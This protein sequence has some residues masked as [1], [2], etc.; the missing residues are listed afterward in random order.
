MKYEREK[1][2]WVRAG[3]VTGEAAG[4]P[5][6]GEKKKTVRKGK[7]EATI[8]ARALALEVT[9][10]AF[11][12]EVWFAATTEGLLASRDKGA[13]WQLFKFAP[14]NLPVA[15][16][17]ASLDGSRVWVVS[18]RGMV[19]TRDGGGT[20]TW[21]DLPFESGG[22]LRLE[23]ADEET[24]VAVARKGM[25]V[26]RDGGKKWVQPAN[27]LPQK[28]GLQDI[29]IIGDAFIASMQT[30]GL[31]LS[32]D[33]GATWTRVEGLLAEGFFPVVIAA[34]GAR[35]IFAASATEGLFAVEFAGQK[36]VVAGG[37]EARR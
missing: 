36:G 16:V 27:G 1:Q 37:G 28:A 21:H 34:E 22:A 7:A 4:L 13:T 14:L 9:D 23:A 31:Y 30:G 8:A 6:P 5:T 18:L 33:R 26:S 15:S 32:Q 35:A 2:A 19:F 11:S 17:R 25:Y 3:T 12:R 20:W 24:L 29:A 10:L